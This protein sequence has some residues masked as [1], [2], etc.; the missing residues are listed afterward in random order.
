MMRRT[1]SKKI[2]MGVT[3]D[4]LIEVERFKST[5]K[6]FILNNVNQFIDFNQFFKNSLNL[7]IN[8]L[9]KATQN[10]SIKFNLHVD[11]VYEN[12]ILH[13]E[14]DI[15]FKT[16]NVAAY[17]QSNFYDLLNKMFNNI[18]KEENDFVT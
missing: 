16:M 14:R 5:S 10:T 7:L 15:S 17:S 2:R 11:C 12:L 3:G 9:E 6:T 8:K 18:L 13:E 4:G 1:I